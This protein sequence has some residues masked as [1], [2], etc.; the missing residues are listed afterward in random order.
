M[1][2]CDDNPYTKH[3]IEKL[4]NGGGDIQNYILNIMKIP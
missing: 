1:K 4:K 3:K 2:S